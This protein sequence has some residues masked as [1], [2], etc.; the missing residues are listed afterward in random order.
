VTVLLALT[1]MSSGMQLLWFGSKAIHQIDYDGMAY[2][3]IAMDLKLGHFRDSLNAFRSPLISWLIA[4]MPGGD[5][6]HTGKV[7]TILTF[8]CTEILLYAFTLALWRSHSAA[9]LAVFLFTLA[10]G[11]GFLTVAFVTPDFL[12]A[13]LVL[14]Y[15]LAL[16]HHLRKG[17]GRWFLAG[18]MHGAAF[19]SKAIALPWLAV[20]TCVAAALSGGS[21]R[22]RIIRVGS[23]AIVPLLVAI[24]WGS[25]LHAKYGVF[26]I[27]SQFKAN[28]LQWTLRGVA[29]RPA[30]KYRVLTD[31]APQTA[32]G[33]GADPMPPDSWE[34]S[35]HPPVAT[36]VSR[37][38]HAEL[39]NLP[40][41]L[42]EIVILTTPGGVLAFLIVGILLAKRPDTAEGVLAITVA[43]GA[44]ALVLAYSM[45]VVD[46]RY[47]FPLLVLFLA[48]ASIFLLPEATKYLPFASPVLRLICIVLVL[49]GTIFSLT[50]WASPMRVQTR[51]W[52]EVCYQTGASL[53][54]RNVKTVVSVGSGP[55]PEHG[56]GWEAGYTS[57]YF[58]DARLLAASV[59]VPEDTQDLLLDVGQAAPDAVIIW[60]TDARRR[61]IVQDALR[62]DYP[63]GQVITDSKIG[64]AGTILYRDQASPR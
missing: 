11:V 28:L 60:D 5:L 17:Q 6:V 49:S 22:Q 61:E 58:G 2:T 36:V 63:S 43:I 57:S 32:Q 56:V 18:T 13:A 33:L 23:A 27:G 29:P 34:W 26:T 10:R 9:A 47:F 40:K 39:Q 20:C 37:V 46:S 54:R 45:L 41:A 48:F 52:Q 15:F 51:D 16:L 8:C 12:L 55:F 38:A 21:W 62:S 1:L 24:F 19:L 3:R 64:E 30:S 25:A 53:A 44:V 50:Y 59:A 4:I 35:Y 7:V 14:A 42:K 31:V